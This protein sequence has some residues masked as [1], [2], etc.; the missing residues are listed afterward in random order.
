MVEDKEP[1][2]GWARFQRPY[3]KIAAVV[4]L[5]AGILGVGFFGPH[6]SSQATPSP[7]NLLQ[8]GATT[9]ASS[10]NPRPSGSTA[11]GFDGL[12]QVKPV[13][14][15]ITETWLPGQISSPSMAIMGG[16]LFYIVDGDQIQSTVVGS[17]GA[18]ETHVVVPPCRGINQLAA[19]GHEL[20]YVVT[21][22]GGPT[23]QV[24]NCGKS[25][26]ISWSLWLLD[27]NGGSPRQVAEGVRPAGS[28]DITEFPVHFALTDSAYAFDRPPTSAAGGPG[29]TVEVHSI[30]G[31]LLWSSKTQRPVAEVML[32]GGT[33]AILTD[34][35]DR[36]AGAV[37]LW[38]SDESNP[39]PAPVDQPAGSASLSPDGSHLA[40]A[41][42]PQAPFP[43]NEPDV[44][45]ETVSLGLEVPLVTPTDR[46]SP[47][48]LR[49]DISSTSRGLLVTWFAT[50]PGGAVY[51]AIRY[52]GGGNGV[53]L[54]SFQEPV[55]MKAQAGTLFWVSESSDGWSKAAFAVNLSTLGLS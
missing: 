1:I 30:D 32:G 42:A 11:A 29:E 21:S 9:A 17:N 49:P 23:A 27:L 39:N 5:M 31:R 22:P 33:L 15:Q 50:A 18:R 13:P 6:P 36:S 24:S 19:A 47:A 37:D 20:A 44:A 34:V 53:V 4:A 38:V 12:R 54:P 28:M 7:A 35:V 45:V 26:Q 55:W 10:G 41:V 52:V 40:W 3:L 46:L 2:E 48:P 43:A 16:R 51:P 14:G 25:G 8:A